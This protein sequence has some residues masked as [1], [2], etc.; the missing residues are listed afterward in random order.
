V[1]KETG[2]WK[3]PLIQFTYLGALAYSGAFLANHLVG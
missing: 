2:G 3:W 1:W